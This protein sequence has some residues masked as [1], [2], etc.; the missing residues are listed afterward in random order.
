MPILTEDIPTFIF[1]HFPTKFDTLCEHYRRGE[2]VYD[3]TTDE[4]YTGGIEGDSLS[5]GDE[6]AQG[7]YKAM[8]IVRSPNDLEESIFQNYAELR[9]ETIEEADEIWR[10]TTLSGY[11][12]VTFIKD[13][14]RM[15]EGAEHLYYIAITLEDEGTNSHAL[16][17]SFPTNDESLV[18]RYRHGENLQA[19]EVIQESSH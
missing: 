17:F 14:S 9:E 19:D 8:L 4:G 6:M 16:L 12:L 11:T 13:F 10:N 5:E 7:L 1:L 18:D 15:E 3:R 2:L